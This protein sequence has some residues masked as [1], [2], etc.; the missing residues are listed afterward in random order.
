[1]QFICIPCCIF[2]NTLSKRK[3][4]I[5]LNEKDIGMFI[6]L[7]IL[8]NKLCRHGIIFENLRDKIALKI[9][10]DLYRKKNC[11]T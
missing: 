11:V 6:S 1:M 4:Y 8:N 3:F 7:I 5:I 10:T 2:W 9:E